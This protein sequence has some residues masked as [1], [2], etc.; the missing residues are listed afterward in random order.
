MMTFRHGLMATSAFGR[1]GP[2]GHGMRKPYMPVFAP[3]GN[4]GGGDEAAAA[5]AARVAAAAEAETA[6]LA[7]EAAKNKPT[8]AEA[9]LLRELMTLKT[10]LKATETEH[11]KFTG[12]DPDKVRDLLARQAEAEAAAAKAE[13]DRLKAAGD[14]ESLKKRMATAHEEEKAAILKQVGAK[15]GEISKLVKQMNELT[16]GSAFAQSQFIT[17]ETVLTP[18]KARR[19]YEDHFELD[20]K[21]RVVGFDAPKNSDDRS[22]LVN[23]RGEPL[24]FDEAMKRIVEADPDK[25]HLLRSK[26]RSG[27]G[28]GNQQHNNNDGNK[29]IEVTGTAR[30]AAILAAKKKA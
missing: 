3:D 19:V 27:S 22:P 30:I 16:I 18:A 23:A 4:E 17:T 15:D 2:E 24:A 8:D 13:E 25:D 11:A 29:P 1:F 28:A 12:I 14:F 21:G 20:E 7:A 9:K 6:R 5:E 26:S 10:K